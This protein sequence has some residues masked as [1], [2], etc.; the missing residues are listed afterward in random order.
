MQRADARNDLWRPLRALSRWIASD[1]ADLPAPARPDAVDWMRIVP[2]ILMHVACLAVFWVGVSATAVAV[3]V[4]LYVLRMF[5][6]TGFYHRYFSHRSFRTSRWLQFLFGLIGASSVQRGPLWWAAHHRHHHAYSDRAEDPHSPRH[7]GFLVSHM[8]WFLTQGGFRPD[9]SRVRDLERY[10]ELRWLDRF[11]IAVPFAL[12]VG[13]LLA[14]N[15]LEAN[16]PGLGTSGAQLLVWGFF[17]STVVLYHATYTINSLCHVFG[18]QRYA[19]GDDSRNNFW[20]A[21]VTFGEG[22]HNNHHHYPSSVRQG[23][24]W[25]EIDLTWYGL[26]LL[27]WLGLVWDLKPIPAAVRD[28]RPG[29]RP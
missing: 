4:A 18:R 28:A 13:L 6:I 29:A 22:W 11:D 16:R 24:Y 25:W 20:L 3:A 23:F 9:L 1:H 14:G 7:K 17:V 2:F 21:L 12:A 27:S 26:K 5:A 15:W 19:T 10:P 8:G